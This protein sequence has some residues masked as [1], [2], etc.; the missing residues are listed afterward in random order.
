MSDFKKLNGYNVKDGRVGDLTSLTTTSKTSI[1]S[2]INEVK[3]ASST[4]TTNIGTLSNLTTDDK[5][6]LVHAIND[7]DHA[8]GS[9]NNL[10]THSKTNLVSA[11]N[12]LAYD[13]GW[14]DL[15]NEIS[16]RRVGQIVYVVG[17]S[18]GTKEIGDGVATVVGTLPVDFRP[19]FMVGFTAGFKGGDH[20]TQSCDIRSDGQIQMYLDT[21]DTT[22]YWIF[23]TCFPL[24]VHSE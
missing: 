13:T 24:P 11:I 19:Q 1:V 10:I 5:D 20:P 7:V 22:S 2:A 14:I 12:E 15:N 3:T 17:N 23:N 21:G 18:S 9:P 4:N 16:Y 6:T 8:V